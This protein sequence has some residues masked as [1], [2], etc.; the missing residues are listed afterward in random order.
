MICTDQ[1]FVLR[2]V[3]TCKRKLRSKICCSIPLLLSMALF[4]TICRSETGL[5]GTLYRRAL[6]AMRRDFFVT[7]YLC[8][9]TCKGSDACQHSA[10]EKSLAYK[11]EEVI[12]GLS[13]YRSRSV[14]EELDRN[15]KYSNLRLYTNVRNKGTGKQASKQ[16]NPCSY[17]GRIETN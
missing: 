11:S 2:S 8:Y 10:S 9:S 17:S 1:R 13:L 15:M 14:F 7:G 6:N 5:L 3:C 4:C 16:T 12:L